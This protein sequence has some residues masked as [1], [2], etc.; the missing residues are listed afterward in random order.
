MLN[1]INQSILAFCVAIISGI[2]IFALV[3]LW[4]MKGSRETNG[5]TERFSRLSNQQGLTGKLSAILPDLIYIASICTLLILELHHPLSIILIA[6]A[7][8]LATW[9]S[10]LTLYRGQPGEEQPS[11]VLQTVETR[12]VRAGGDNTHSHDNERTYEFLHDESV[13]AMSQTQEP[14]SG[15]LRI[16]ELRAGQVVATYFLHPTKLTLTFGRDSNAD[17]ILTDVSASR[18]HF[19]I[20]ERDNHY[21][22]E[23]LKSKNR[24]HLNGELIEHNVLHEIFFMNTISAADQVFVVWDDRPL[25]TATDAIKTREINV[26]TD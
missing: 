17:V 6:G 24:T 5:Y 15:T 8:V 7:F 9:R 23:D 20:L 14:I 12:T 4:R 11:H 3:N 26:V 18:K 19:R 10:F 22:V 2:I 1:L 21:F 16:L 13:L 25:R